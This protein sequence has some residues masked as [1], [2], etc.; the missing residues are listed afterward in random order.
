MNALSLEPSK[1]W[2]SCD[3]TF[4]SVA[5]ID[6]VRSADNRWIKQ[7]KGLFCV[8]NAN[9][10]VMTWKLTKSLSFDEIEVC[11]HQLHERLRSQG[12]L[13][14]W[15]YIDNC[16][17]WKQKLLSRFRPQMKVL[18]DLFHAVQ[19]ISSKIYRKHSFRHQCIQS[20]RLVFRDSGDQGNERSMNTPSPAVMESNLLRFQ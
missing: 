13:V 15:F 10:Q 14:K 6:I 7:Y 3:H 11:L 16:C 20:L 4:H 9:E 12:I 19:R 17:S 2:L 1:V 18:L 8:L 5:N